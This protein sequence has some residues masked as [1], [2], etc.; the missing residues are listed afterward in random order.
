MENSEKQVSQDNKVLLIEKVGKSKLVNM[1]EFRRKKV[2]DASLFNSVLSKI[3]AKTQ[4]NIP[5]D[6]AKIQIGSLQDSTTTE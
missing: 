4:V 1:Q 3:E 2:L 5:A 6:R